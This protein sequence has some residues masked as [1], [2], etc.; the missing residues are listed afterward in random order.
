M[1]I[2]DEALAIVILLAEVKESQYVE[3]KGKKK[4]FT[5]S[6]VVGYSFVVA[7][8]TLLVAIAIPQFKSGCGCR[9]HSSYTKADLH[10][11]YLGCKA[12]WYDNGTDSVC[13]HEIAQLT[14]YG[15]IKSPDVE[16]VAFGNESDFLAL[17]Y[18]KKVPEVLK[19]DALGSISR[20]MDFYEG[21]KMTASELL[22]FTGQIRHL[23]QFYNACVSFWDKA[24]PSHEC[25]VDKATQYG[26]V[27]S[28]DYGIIATGGASLF[29][30]TLSEK[31]NQIPRELEGIALL[32]NG[33][34]VFSEEEIAKANLE[35]LHMSC[36]Y[37]WK[38]KGP[39]EVC[40][41]DRASRYGYL[42]SS[43]YQVVVAG[44][45][46]IFQASLEY[47]KEVGDSIKTVELTLLSNGKYKY[48]G[49]DIYY[50][51]LSG[52]HMACQY[53]WEEFGANKSCTPKQAI[54]Y[55]YAPLPGS[56]VV[57]DGEESFFTALAQLE[58]SGHIF[59]MDGESI[60]KA[61]HVIIYDV[62]SGKPIREHLL[63][64]NVTDMD[65]T[66]DGRHIMEVHGRGSPLY[67]LNLTTGKYEMPLTYNDTNLQK[68]HALYN[69]TGEFQNR[70]DGKRQLVVLNSKSKEVLFV[71]KPNPK[72]PN[73]I[74][75]IRSVGVSPDFKQFAVMWKN[76]YGP[77]Y[78]PI[79]QTSPLLKHSLAFNKARHLFE[80]QKRMG[81]VV[82]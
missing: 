15:Y 66:N 7:V 21:E 57:A 20:V 45:A 77:R 80:T 61:L 13:T 76:S 37:L 49:N 70:Q 23:Q 14:T 64:G 60:T 18:N 4:F 26:F 78:D 41:I 56:R 27:P 74:E 11:V 62:D 75:H 79:S 3:P 68:R 55:G 34:F 67:L 82:Q 29:Q 2:R 8:I 58:S 71:L 17:A 50:A 48:G 73:D 36:Q 63:Q 47:Q 39:A 24:G 9:A 33:R 30:A 46:P 25:S 65:F 52:L 28:L 32:A 42:P 54:R 12:Y 72:L 16:L 81:Q 10:N 59:R 35:R 43:K 1:K 31:K 69:T 38:E 40:S 53:F 6:R 22:R 5:T 44:A 19:V 51:N